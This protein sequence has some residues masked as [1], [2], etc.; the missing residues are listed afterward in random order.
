MT[1]RL[2]SLSKK[3]NISIKKF[4]ELL[5]ICNVNDL[6]NNNKPALYYI[7]KG[8][9]NNKHKL[10]KILL[11]NNAECINGKFNIFKY[12]YNFINEH[13][14]IVMKRLIT[15]LFQTNQNT[16]KVIDAF[17]KNNICKIYNEYTV[18]ILKYV[19]LYVKIGE[20]NITKKIFGVIGNIKN[21]LNIDLI[22]FLYLIFK[23]GYKWGKNNCDNTSIFK[24]LIKSS[25]NITDT[26]L[27]TQFIDT[28]IDGYDGFNINLYDLMPNIKTITCSSI[29][30]DFML[31]KLKKTNKLDMDNAINLKMVQYNIC[32]KF[33]ELLIYDKLIGQNNIT[34]K[35]YIKR[36]IRLK[37][38]CGSNISFM[39]RLTNDII[40]TIILC[41][42]NL[43][44]K[45]VGK[46][47]IIPFLGNI[48]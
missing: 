24:G 48:L 14:V 18:Q 1:T 34:D 16:D 44:I 21:Q 5:T 33:I 10:V 4:K 23:N 46:Y 26:K 37:S 12:M 15:R 17:I 36:Q 38:I 7:C 20:K 11:N 8:N 9:F 35:D 27:L 6:D 29:I 2:I 22:D 31:N 25:I 42:K 19:L 3:N 13:D 40:L 41:S 28:I 43:K 45:D 32:P 47:I 30:T 39:S